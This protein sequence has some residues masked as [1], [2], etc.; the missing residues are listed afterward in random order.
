MRQRHWKQV[1]RHASGG[2]A[3]LLGR[4]GTFD[5][6]LSGRAHFRSTNGNEATQ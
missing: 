3:H 2:T 5:P 1:I 4:G 6:K